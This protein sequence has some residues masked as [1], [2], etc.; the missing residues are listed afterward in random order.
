MKNK[1]FWIRVLLLMFCLTTVVSISS[2]KADINIGNN[3]ELGTRF[4]D[5]VITDNYDDAYDLI[6]N[7]VTPSDFN[8]YWQII[9]PVADGAK[10]YKMEQVG[11]NVNR[12][13]GQTTRT[14]A[15]E[16][17]FDNGKIA[18]LRIITC[19]GIDGI[20][21]LY[22]SDTTDFISDTDSFVPTVNVIL[23]IFSILAI[24]FSVWMLV[25]CIRRK[26][27]H[28]VLWLILIF[29]GISFTITIGETSGIN[30]MIGLI[31]RM[32][33]IV[34]DIGAMAVKI[35]IIIPLGAILYFI[36]RKKLTVIPPSADNDEA[37]AVDTPVSDSVAET[38]S[39][40]ADDEA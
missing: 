22:F 2:C 17:Y 3:T 9:Q 5:C 28:K 10:T 26:I 15:Y 21:G 35:N 13:N 19:D 38:K 12:S 27:N 24:A 29:L 14:T 11:W 39:P 32:S 23:F 16:I 8:D 25:D 18:L 40:S 37:Q 6:K 20:A 36:L 34:A 33:T 7:T 30:F 31:L 4:M 1:K